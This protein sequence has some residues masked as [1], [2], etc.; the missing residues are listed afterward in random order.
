MTY[1]LLNL[2]GNLI[3]D[4]RMLR[5]EEHSPVEG[6]DGGASSRCVTKNG[7]KIPI[8]TVYFSMKRMENS[9]RNINFSPLQFFQG[10]FPGHRVNLFSRNMK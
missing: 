9:Y 10:C 3:L 6:K 7:L 8:A 4:V 2:H 5:H 1:D